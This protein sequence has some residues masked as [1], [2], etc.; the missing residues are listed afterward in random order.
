MAL[1]NSQYDTIIKSFE[2]KQNRNRR[3]LEERAA[4]VYS[5]VE[6]YKALDD[7]IASI[8]VSQG[9]KLLEGDDNA[10]VELKKTI[11]E[12]SSMK[13]QL[14]LSAG[15]PADYL[16]PVYD[17]PDCR[18]T[19]YQGNNKC[20]CFKQAIITMLYEQ[21]GI[22]NVLE[23]ENFSSLSYDYYEG[24]DL[25]RFKNTVVTCKNFINN[26]NSDY[27][28][29]FFYGTVGTGKSFLSGCVAKELIENGHS[30]I[31]F[32]AAGLF[33]TLSKI[34]FD[35][36]NQDGLHKEYEDLFQCDLLIVDDLGTEYTNNLINSELFS[37]IN[38]R[39]IRQKAT[40]ISTNLSLE[41]FRNRYSDRVFSRITSNYEICKLTGPDIR[42]YKK[43]QQ[44]RK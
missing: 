12:L 2:E 33:D 9:R 43:R 42:M 13:K 6:G 26:F 17:C 39:H 4:Y 38:D 15:L 21:S 34:K 28:N 30:V 10:L 44:N 16:D 19:G 8:S 32:S 20:H 36:K 31:Y 22:Q 18:D 7:S 29:L 11:G 3:L 14:L 37:L 23:S 35:Y 41:D 24:E 40:I 5:H 25:T 1:T 27:H